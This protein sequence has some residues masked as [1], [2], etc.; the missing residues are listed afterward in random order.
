MIELSL[1]IN[2]HLSLL[3]IQAVRT[4]PTKRQPKD[5]EVCTYH[6]YVDKVFT[7][8]LKH[9]FGDGISLMKEMIV[10]YDLW[11]IGQDKKN[12]KLSKTP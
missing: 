8:A 9:P 2:R 6:V 3:S 10:H 1:K 5:G 4:H 11:K 12:E 7:G